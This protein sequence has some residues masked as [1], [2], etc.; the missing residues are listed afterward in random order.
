MMRQCRQSIECQEEEILHEY[1]SGRKTSGGEG[2][3]FLDARP[4]QIDVKQQQQNAET[5]NRALEISICS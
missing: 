5:D 1:G 2:G 3:G 4:G